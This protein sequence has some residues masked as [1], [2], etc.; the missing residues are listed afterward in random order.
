MTTPYYNDWNSL[1]AACRVDV[2][3]GKSGS[4][5]VERF[6]ITDDQAQ[7]HNLRCSITGSSRTVIAGTYTR[8]LFGDRKS[9]V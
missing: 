4:V 9:V 1:V 2:P 5:T 6:T 8:L 3:E 7:F